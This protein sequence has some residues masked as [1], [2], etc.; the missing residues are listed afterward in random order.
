VLVGC[1]VALRIF[2]TIIHEHYE[3]LDE[4]QKR[5]NKRKN[6]QSDGVANKP[7][8]LFR[9]FIGY[10][11]RIF[12]KANF[13]TGPSDLKKCGSVDDVK[14]VNESLDVTGGGVKD[15]PFN[16]LFIRINAIRIIAKLFRGHKMGVR[17]AESDAKKQVLSNAKKVDASS[18]LADHLKTCRKSENGGKSSVQ[19]AKDGGHL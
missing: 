15:K 3:E 16:L 8:S 6:I 12:G 17:E 18:A 2:G 14:L 19:A 7:V 11:I 10:Q 5:Q 9:K 13:E 4:R 1:F